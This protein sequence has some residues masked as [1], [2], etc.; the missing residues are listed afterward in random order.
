VLASG[1]QE[2][3]RSDHQAVEPERTR[4]HQ[5]SGVEREVLEGLW[6]ETGWGMTGPKIF[7]STAIYDGVAWIYLT[8]ILVDR[9]GRI[10]DRWDDDSQMMATPPVIPRP[11]EE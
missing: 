11:D 5:D 7:F 8:F 3:E 1:L 2:G 4:V 10:S 6:I 9:S